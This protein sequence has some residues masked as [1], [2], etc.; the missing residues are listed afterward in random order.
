[1]AVIAKGLVEKTLPRDLLISD[2]GLSNHARRP[3]WHNQRFGTGR[4]DET[5]RDEGT[6]V[7]YSRVC[8]S[9]R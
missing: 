6:K 9:T 4:D 8:K 7:V 2:N 5:R 3:K 1:M